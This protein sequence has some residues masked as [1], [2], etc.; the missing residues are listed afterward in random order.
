LFDARI[1]S[2]CACDGHG[3]LQADDIFCLDD[4]VRILD[5]IEFS[6]QLRHCDV[7]ADVTFLVMDLER[8]G[9]TE[10]AAQLLADYQELAG[11]EFPDALIH[12]YCASHAYVRAKVACLRS[13]Q[14]VR[15]A[16]AEARKFQAVAL[17]HLRKGRVRMVLVGGLPGT[18]KSTLAG[19]LAAATGWTV[20]RSDQIRQSLSEPGAVQAPPSQAGVPGHLMGR[21]S[22]SV[23]A[24]VYQ[25]LLRQAEQALGL[26]ES[27]I[28]DASWIDAD[29]RDAAREVADRTSSDLVPLCCEASPEE[30]DT[31]ISR[32]LAEQ[33][34]VSEATP[35]VRRAMSGLMDPWPGSD[36]IDT[37]VATPEQAVERALGAVQFWRSRDR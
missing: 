7:C 17:D 34:D 8:L 32:R 35:E 29:W 24:E 5:C 13:A 36:V 10:E 22:P 30:A 3:D 19:G 26:G 6:D 21:Y 33:A 31:R 16:Q 28:L 11:A 23:T 4:G 9:H 20:L 37:S 12:H 27:V 15:A 25:Q 18:G 2:G 1:A 14:G